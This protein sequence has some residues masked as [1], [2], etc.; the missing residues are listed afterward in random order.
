MSYLRPHR[1]TNVT[2]FQW[3][4]R[5]A[6]SNSGWL[7][8][9]VEKDCLISHQR[10]DFHSW[11]HTHLYIYICGVHVIYEQLQWPKL[12]YCFKMFAQRWSII[13]C[14]SCGRTKLKTHFLLAHAKHFDT[15]TLWIPFSDII[16]EVTKPK[17]KLY[18]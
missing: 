12:G 11:K 10:N 17:H 13:S 6:G 8:C 14:H 1:I 4:V 18:Q 3:D 16:D 5:F 9:L 15:R 7:G 2:N